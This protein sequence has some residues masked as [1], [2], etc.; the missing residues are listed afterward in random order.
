MGK[1]K[2][3]IELLLS[4]DVRLLNDLQTTKKLLELKKQYDETQER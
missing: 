4:S 1:L 3:Q 2:E